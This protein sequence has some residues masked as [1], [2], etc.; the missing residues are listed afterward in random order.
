MDL[1]SAASAHMDQM[2]SI[3][4]GVSESLRK[5]WGEFK[6]QGGFWD[7]I[8]RFVHAVDWTEPW[9]V[10]L[11]VFHLILVAVVVATRKRSNVQA[12]LFMAM[13]LSVFF[14]ER[15][16]TLLRRHWK[17]FAGQP[18][19]DSHG[20]FMSTVWSGPMLLISTLILVNSMV[21]LTRM[22]IKWKRA[23]LKHK[24][25]VAREKKE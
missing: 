15:L 9:L 14:A 22:L 1:G 2:A 4:E 19:F 12:V 21:T 8:L 13:L 16:N 7:P 25:R 11:M 3:V 5:Q 18:Y 6:Q 23:E 20:V 10:G 17:S 24:A